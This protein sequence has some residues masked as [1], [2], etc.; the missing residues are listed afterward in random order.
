MDGLLTGNR[1]Q[2]R[3]AFIIGFSWLHTRTTN[4]QFLQYRHIEVP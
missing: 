3:Q 2:G 1:E 4:Q